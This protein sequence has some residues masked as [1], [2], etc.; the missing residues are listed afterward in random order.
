MANSN[1]HRSTTRVLDALELIAES[2]KD[3]FDLT[4]ICQQ[5]DMA[6]NSVLPILR[7]LVHR[8]YLSIDPVSGKYTIGS[9][10]FQ[11]GNAYLENFDTMKEIKRELQNIT[12]ACSETSHF[13]TLKSGNAFYI[14][15]ADSPESI[16]MAAAVGLGLPAYSTGIG[17]ALLTDCTLDDLMKLYP[18][19]LRPLTPKT[20]TDFDALAAQ[21]NQ[22]HSCGFSC[23]I[24]ECEQNIRCLAVP[25]RKNGTIIAAISVAIPVYRYTPGKEELI[26][27]LLKNSKQRLEYIFQSINV[28][29]DTAK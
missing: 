13:A 9:Y 27:Y 11:I 20:I 29:I 1:E 14:A 24:E 16:R 25:L 2:G 15:K 12:N 8:H 5:M 18:K 7:T 23:E 4:E 22:A 26:L 6:K 3:G 10:A 28:S 21:L 19:G 17:K